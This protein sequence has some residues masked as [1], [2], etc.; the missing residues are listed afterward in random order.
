MRPARLARRV[1]GTGARGS[2][3]AIAGHNTGPDLNRYGMYQQLMDIVDPAE[4]RHLAVSNSVRLCEL[5]GLTGQIESADYPDHNLLHL[6]FSDG[7]FDSV[8]SD[9]VLEHL[10]GDPQLALSE[11]AR[12]LRSGGRAIHT[13]CL[14]N[15]V[16]CAPG[17]FGDFW[18]FTPE[19]LRL[20][21]EAAGLDVVAVGGHGNI[22]IVAMTWAGVQYTPVPHSP[23]HPLHWIA[24]RNNA[25]WPVTTWVVAT[26]P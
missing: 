18:R 19:A 24:T 1:L 11:S 21:A 10:Q 16:H 5:L 23:R 2:L 22:F 4:G 8:V 13:T 12:V 25:E 14:V 7:Q 17:S 9:Q 26:K 6:P 15:P 3:K 20:L